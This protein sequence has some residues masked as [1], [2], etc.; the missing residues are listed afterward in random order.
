MSVARKIG[1]YAGSLFDVVGASRLPRG[2]ALLVVGLESTPERNLDEFS[3][4]NGVFW[5][6]ALQPDSYHLSSVRVAFGL[7]PPTQARPVR[8]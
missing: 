1:D 8:R 5:P 3:W 6:I 7:G 2:E 4:P